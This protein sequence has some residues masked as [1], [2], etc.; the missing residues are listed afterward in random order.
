MGGVSLFLI[1]LLQAIMGSSEE[2]AAKLANK[3]PRAAYLEPTFTEEEKIKAKK[4]GATALGLEPTTQVKCPDCDVQIPVSS[5]WLPENACA[6][7]GLESSI[8]PRCR[9][10]IV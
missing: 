1:W 3:K 6:K 5:F 9:Q 7:G 4:K 10:P 8:C 2:D